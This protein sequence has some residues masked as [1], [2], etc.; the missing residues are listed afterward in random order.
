M[1]LAECKVVVWLTMAYLRRYPGRLFLTAFSIIVAACIVVWVVSGYDA[2]A[3]KFEEFEEGYLG[4]YQILVLPPAP[5]LFGQAALPASVVGQLRDDPRVVVA[6]P[7]FQTRANIR[8]AEAPPRQREES[9]APRREIVPGELVRPGRFNAGPSLV[10]T[11]ARLPVHPLRSG[12]WL[13]ADDAGQLVGVLTAATAESWEV[14]VG[15][16]V[17][18]GGMG[19]QTENKIT[20]VGIVEQPQNLPGP[21]FRIGLPPSRDQALTRGPASSALFV[22]META[23]VLTGKDPEANFV[24]LSLHEGTDSTA[25]KLEWLGRFQSSLPGIEMHTL[26]DVAQE[27]DNSTTFEGVRSQA[28][29]ATGMSLL[30]ALFII[31]TTLSMGVHERIRQFAMLRAIGMTKGQIA[32]ML[33]IESIALGLIGWGGGLLAGWGLLA[34]LRQWHPDMVAPDAMLGTWSIV[35]SGLC[36]FGGA[37]AAALLPAWKATRIRP[38]EAMAVQADVPIR[39]FPWMLTLGGLILIAINPTLV[40]LVPMPDTLRYFASAAIGC[41]SMALGFLLII[42]AVI[43]TV[44]LILAPILA[45]GMGVHPRLLSNQLSSNLWRSLGITAALTLGLGLFV[46]M[47]TWGYSMLGPFLP[48]DWS[49]E[50]IVKIGPSGLPESGVEEIRKV[51]GVVSD[52]CIPLAA[53]QVKF[54]TDVTGAEVRA[55]AS[56]QDNCVMVGIDANMALGGAQPMFDFRFV[57]GNRDEALTKLQNGRYCLVPDHFQRES[58][59]GVGDR[60]AVVP[61]SDPKNPIEYEIAGVVNMDGWHWMSKVGLRNRGGGRAAGLMFSPYQQVRSDFGINRDMFFWMNLEGTETEDEIRESLLSIAQA[62]ADTVPNRSPQGPAE[63][64]GMFGGRGFGPGGRSPSVDMRSVEGVRTEMQK[65]ASGI[66]WAL[67]QLPLITLA[68]TA[69]GVVNA[70][71]ASVRARRWEMGVLRAMGTTRMGLLR[72]ILAEAILIGLAACLLSLAFGV[73]AGYC[74]TGV[75]RYVNVRGGLVTPLVIPWG[76]LAIGFGITLGMCLLA[77]LSPALLTARRD[78][79]GLLKDGRSVT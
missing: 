50:L 39:R 59:L 71:A 2:L 33:M 44:E 4:R 30:A 47:Q 13:N 64:R 49:P 21:S 31:F 9:P 16:A 74:G 65:R 5:D 76:Q 7:I 51:P 8:P 38:L 36:A 34:I 48:G 45:R 27:I 32:I 29:A 43:T 41:V 69:L 3:S 56:R 10:G 75:T 78:T 1:S 72:M 42:P 12:R 6:E 73:M 55:T 35:F 53:E 62:N 25:F 11:E 19:P 79:L 57:E 60:F 46:T 66:I 14:E 22:S 54:A 17:L 24:G 68:V 37:L 67:C 61:S 77:A 28:Y 63:G 15:D 23:A 70:V 20:I 40:F 58:G 52:Q 18:L 26:A